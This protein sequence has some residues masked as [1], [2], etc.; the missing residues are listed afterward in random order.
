M[1]VAVDFLNE[2]GLNV[3]NWTKH[4]YL[5]FTICFTIYLIMTYAIHLCGHQMYLDDDR[6]PVAEQILLVI[7][8]PDDEAMFFTPAILELSKHNIIHLLCLS[9]GSKGGAG[10]VREKELKSSCKKFGILSHYCVDD[11]DLRDSEEWSLTEIR[12]QI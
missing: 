7:A 2:Y 8:H 10:L 6:L 4:G 5:I 9:N 12:N 11:P 3:A 1:E